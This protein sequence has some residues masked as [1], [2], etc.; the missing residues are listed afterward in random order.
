MYHE[1]AK[2]SFYG[3][4]HINI[5]ADA[6]THSCKEVFAAVAYSWARDV[7]AYPPM[8]ILL[9]GNQ[10]TCVEQEMADDVAV[11]SAR[12]K[13]DRVAAFRQLQ[14]L[15]HMVHHLTDGRM[16]INAFRLPPDVRLT[17]V[18]ENEVRVVTDNIALI[19]NVAT[20]ATRLVLPGNVDNV[21]IL[22]VGLDQGSVGAAGVAFTQ[23][24]LQA[25]VHCRFDK[26]HRI[27]REIK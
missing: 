5:V 16:S 11:L 1:R 8:Q 21:P 20:G 2:E 25:L 15:S 18:L 12:R 24:H 7:A 17:P 4:E 26:L 10:V 22:T 14:G 19:H 9:P 23:H 13:L 6:G 27:A 3:Q